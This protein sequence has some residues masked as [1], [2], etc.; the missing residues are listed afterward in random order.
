[1]EK[2]YGASVDSGV[3]PYDPC[4]IFDPILHVEML[5][6]HVTIQQG[7]VFSTS[8]LFPGA[9][10]SSYRTHLRIMSRRNCSLGRGAHH[11]DGKI[12]LERKWL[13]DPTSPSTVALAAKKLGYDLFHKKPSFLESAQAVFEQEGLKTILQIVGTVAIAVLLFW[14]GLKK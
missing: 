10:C 14:L 8:P 2:A 13:G 3:F 9:V 5:D 6:L 12:L 4:W 1:L 11:A 7:D